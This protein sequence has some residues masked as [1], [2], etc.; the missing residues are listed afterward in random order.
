MRTSQSGLRAVRPE[1]IIEL[2]EVPPTCLVAD[3][4]LF[5]LSGCAAANEQID[6]TSGVRSY[7]T[8]A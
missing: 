6:N 3:S 1:L 2:E 7:K 5:W 4:P 8:E